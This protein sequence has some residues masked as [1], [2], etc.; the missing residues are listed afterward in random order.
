MDKSSHFLPAWFTV[1]MGTGGISLLFY[2]C[3]Y[4]ADSAPIK[5]FS[6]I[7]F[8]FNLVLFVLFN[9]I[10]LWRYI[11]YPDISVRTV[12][13]P[14]QSLYYSTYS[15]ALGPLISVAVGLLY[16][17]YG[18]G[19]KA[20]LYFIWGFWW[21]DVMTSFA[22]AFILVHIMFTR[23][24]HAISTMTTVWMVP[25]AALTVA[26]SAGASIASSL[27]QVSTS[28]TLLTLA[29]S[30]FMVIVGL[31]ICFM[32]STLY[33]LRLLIYGVPERISVLSSFIALGPT[34][35][36]GNA[37]ILIGQG[38]QAI[39]PLKYGDSDLLRSA[40]T[41]PTINVICVCTAFLMWAVT[42]MWMFYAVLAV[43]DVVRQSRF[44]FGLPF[45]GLIFPNVVYAN[46]TVELYR[47]L[48][49]KFF[50]IWGTICAVATLVLWVVVFLQTVP[51][52]WSGVIFDASDL[53]KV[54]ATSVGE[55]PGH[56]GN[57]SVANTQSTYA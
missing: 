10:T 35:Q 40:N 27:E 19:G 8:F 22:S 5:A 33:L 29:V 42:T 37:I 31:V 25:P 16:N 14:R 48:D 1:N 36:G 54:D 26:A 2:N 21:F 18:F 53:E 3:A 11:L 24:K 50:R 23:Q 28:Y 6:A 57:G 51:L 56:K 43:Q 45:W 32:L 44:S 52:V 34:G 38:F 15:L 46:L 47:A 4:A 17:E 13:H 20:F 7:F 30:S 55:T 12:L 41:G 49:S 9:I 39:L